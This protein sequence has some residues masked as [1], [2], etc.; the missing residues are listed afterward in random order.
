MNSSY[1][2]NFRELWSLWPTREISGQLKWYF[3]VQLSFW[4]QQLLAINLEK[5][6]KDYAQMFTHHVVTSLLMYVCY[7]YRYTNIGNV[8]LCIMDVV[9]ILLPV[10]STLLAEVTRC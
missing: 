2:L 9:D 7:A 1:W 4:L 8:I 5:P 6:R 10:K 3:L